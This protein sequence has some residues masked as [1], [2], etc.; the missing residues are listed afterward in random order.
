[1]ATANTPTQLKNI[2]LKRLGAP[3]NTINVTDDQLYEAI[4][5]AVDIY[6][7]YHYDGV[8][9]MYL[10][11]TLT[12]DEVKS[13]LIDT[14]VKLQAVTRVFRSSMS[15][16][17]GWYDGAIFDAGWQAGADL[18]K[19]LSG[20][21]AGCA[22]GKGSGLFSGGGYA[23][24]MYDAFYQYMELL[25]RFF[26]PDFNFWFNTDSSKLKILNDGNL[27]EGQVILVECYVAAGVYVDQ[28]YVSQPDAT[29]GEYVTSATQNYHNPYSY[30]INSTSSIDPGVVSMTQAIYN[31][32]WLKE[33]ATA[34]TKLQWGQNLK[35]FQG[36]PLPGGITVNG[37][38]IYDEANAE[39]ETLRKELLLLQ[40]PLPFY[41]E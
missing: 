1:M 9:K 4:D 27:Y 19:N 7:D 29:T 14:G 40:E 35:K 22:C 23:L 38:Q 5:R 28:S 17:I 33:M 30:T 37:Q 10:V 12:E 32:R 3:V 6:V 18:L 34:Y 25:Q 8:N 21:M 31:N 11:H 39:I 41:L 16:G 20:S 2:I 36:Q 26:S 15:I 24:A 13:G